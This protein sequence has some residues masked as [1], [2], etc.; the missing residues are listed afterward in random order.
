M[1]KIIKQ[2]RSV[3][4]NCLIEIDAAIVEENGSIYMDKACKE[5]GFFRAMLS[6][7][8]WYYNGL[9]Q[10]Y[11]ALSPRGHP[12]GDK[13]IENFQMYVTSRCN[14]SCNVCYSDS[15]SAGDDISLA[16]IK[17][18]ISA[19]KKKN[20]GISILGGEPTVREDLPEIIKTIK[21]AGHR[22]ILFTNGLKLIDIEYLK[23]LKKFG[24]SRAGVWFDTLRSDEIYAKIRVPDLFDKKNR[25]LASLK[26][27]DMS[28]IMVMVIVRGI[29]EGEIA[30]IVDFA[31]KNSFI[32]TLNIRSYAKI[33]RHYFSASEEFANDELTE[34]IAEKTKNLITLEEFYLFQKLIYAIKLLFLNKPTC[35][36][37]QSIYIPRGNNKRMRDIFN[38]D[39]LERILNRVEQLY[40]ESPH[41]ARKYLFKKLVLKFISNPF[42]A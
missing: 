27:N 25:V 8:A 40:M 29:N 20:R 28:T 36:Q 19:I 17:K 3:C 10:F 24:L 37:N 38:L 34:L 33:G 32:D 6:K 31:R 42:F 39:E 9:N 22:P 4:P 15:N 7:Y 1:K 2:T 5:H 41:A 23:K 18:M 30:D 12:F 16:E 35:Y 26:A 13:D 21:Q 14:L 11:N